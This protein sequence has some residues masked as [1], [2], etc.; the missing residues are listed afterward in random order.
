MGISAFDAYREYVALKNHF[1][2]PNYDYIKYNGKTGLK[3]DSFNKRKDKL[4]FEKLAKKDNVHEF[5]IANLSD[6]PKLWIRDLAYS[7]SAENTYSSWKKRSQSLTYNFKNEV[8]EHLC[9]PFN[10]NFTAKPGEHPHLMRSYLA[11]RITLETFC[12]LLDLTKAIPSWDSKMEYDPVW[13]DLSMKVK[14]YTPF[15]RYDKD[16][17]KKIILDFYDET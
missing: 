15:I 11:G 5:L 4:F 8:E 17:F 6:N 12:I 13:Q 3:V 7:D 16:K 10:F 9:K 1:T 2:K 14:K